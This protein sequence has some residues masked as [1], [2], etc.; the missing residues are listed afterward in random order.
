MDVRIKFA[1]DSYINIDVLEKVD[2]ELIKN[3]NDY[4]EKR[5][6]YYNHVQYL[7]YGNPI[8]I[9]FQN[10]SPYYKNIKTK[11]ARVMDI[12]FAIKQRLV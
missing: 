4:K 7:T 9:L 5:S 2:Q 1:K 10:F 8:K 11:K 3:Q 6:F 12:F